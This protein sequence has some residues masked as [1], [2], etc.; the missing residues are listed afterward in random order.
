MRSLIITNQCFHK[1]K[2]T[3]KKKNS[4]NQNTKNSKKAAENQSISTLKTK[5]K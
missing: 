4:F 1:S 2:K 5:N 3:E